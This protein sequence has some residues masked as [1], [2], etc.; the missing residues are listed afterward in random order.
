MSNFIVLAGFEINPP[1]S[2]PTVATSATAGSMAAGSYKYLLTYRTAFGETTAGPV[3]ASGIVVPTPPATV[4]S[5][6]LSNLPMLPDSNY[7]AVRRLYRTSVGDVLP[8]RF[9]AEIPNATSTY[10]DTIADGALGGNPPTVNTAASNEK[11]NGNLI[12][13]RPVI[14]ACDPNINATGV[15]RATASFLPINCEVAFVNTPTNGNGVVLPYINADRIGLS[16]NI[17]NN[18]VVNTLLVYPQDALTVVAGGTPGT[19]YAL[20]GGLA[21]TLVCAGAIE[22]RVLSSTEFGGVNAIP[23]LIDPN[24]YYAMM[25][26][27]P[28]GGLYRSQNNGGILP[29]TNAITASFVLAGTTLTVTAVG[30]A[31]LAPGQVLTGGTISVG[32]PAV[33]IVS[34]LTGAAGDVGT[35]QVSQAQLAG[36][37]CT[38]ANSSATTPDIIY[39]RTV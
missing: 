1:L 20:K 16:I 6:L 18:S 34:Q 27:V 12:M 7:S 32:P 23:S 29:T 14:R 13:G 22:W 35:Y 15:D 8:Y 24:N 21:V 39:M 3:S 2:A 4:G 17:R 36:V 28:L 38:V 26:G 19:P 10:T 30:A 5:L 25:A 33:Y 37:T 31:T 11:I 9:V